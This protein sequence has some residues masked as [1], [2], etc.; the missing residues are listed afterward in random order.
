MRATGDYYSFELINSVAQ[1]RVFT[2]EE[3]MKL[4]GADAEDAT[5]YL[6]PKLKCKDPCILSVDVA[7]EHDMTSFVVTRMGPLSE[8][9]WDPVTQEGKTKFCNTIWAYEEKHMQDTDAAIKIYDILDMFEN[10]QIV[11]LDKRGGGSSVRDQLYRVV[12]E[13]I[14]DDYEILFDPDDDDEGGIATLLKDKRNQMMSHNNRLRLVSYSDEDNTKVN[15][16]LKTAM[17]EERFYFCGGDEKVDE[18][19]KFVRDYINVM[20]RQFRMIQI[21][22]TKNWLNFST[23]NPDTDLKDLYS[24]VVYGW[25]EIMKLVHE[26]DIPKKSIASGLAPVLTLRT[27]K[28]I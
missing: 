6:R 15:R 7:R 28:E 17:G 24:A 22:P 3:Y 20:P 8:D 19:I 10:I 14:I 21:K 5:M 4:E 11:A 2:D 25:G 13:G 27:R 16:S 18:E 23:P 26:S 12:K 9:P 1:K